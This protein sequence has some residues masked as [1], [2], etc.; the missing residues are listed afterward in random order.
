[1]GF[2]DTFKALGDPT[3]REIITLLKHGKLSA[4]DIVSHFSSTNATISHHLSVLKNADLICDEKVGKY[5][6]YELNTSVIDE[7]LVWITALKGD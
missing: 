2:Q 4:G 3:R 6:Y 1:M 5:I 7:I